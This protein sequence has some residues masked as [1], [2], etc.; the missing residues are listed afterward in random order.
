VLSASLGGVMTADAAN[1]RVILGDPTGGRHSRTGPRST[2]QIRTFA[3]PVKSHGHAES[4]CHADGGIS[5]ARAL[6]PAIC[7]LAAEREIG[8]LL[9]GI[10][11]RAGA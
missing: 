9:C 4:H 1:L 2:R 11:R 3:V 10:A 6:V 8:Q 7:A 5:L